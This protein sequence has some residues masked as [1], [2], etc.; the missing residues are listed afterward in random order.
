LSNFDIVIKNGLII[1]GSNSPGYV[2]D[3]GIN[4]NIITAIGQIPDE[5]SKETINAVGLA[6]TPGFI[7]I[8][9]HS[10]FSLLVNPAAESQVHQGVTSEIM[11]NCGFS[12][13]PVSNPEEMSK[14]TFGYHPSVDIT[15]RT[16]EEYLEVLSSHEPGVNTMNFV[17]HGALRQMVVGTKSQRPNPD[18]LKQMLKILEQCLDQ[19]AMGLSTGLEYWPGSDASYEELSTICEVL[20]KYD[21]FH[22]VH[23]RNRDMLFEYALAEVLSLARKTGV[24]TQIAHIQP[25]YGVPSK[26]MEHALKMIDWAREDAC[27]VSIDI[28]PNEW[29]HTIISSCLPQWAFDGGVNKLLARLKDKDTREKLKKNPNCIWQLIPDGKW[30]RLMIL[31]S[32]NN[33]Q[34][35]GKTLAEI[36]RLRDQ[37]PYDSVLDILLEE[38]ENLGRAMWAAYNFKNDDLALCLKKEYCMVMSD[39]MALAPYGKLKNTIASISGY[40][41]TARFLE[42]Y[43]IKQK[44]MPLEDGIHR[45]TGLPAVIFNIPKRGFIKPSYFADINII[46]IANI[47]D[48]STMTNLAQYPTGFDYVMV[49]GKFQMVQGKR[50]PVNNGQVLKRNIS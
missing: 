33:P 32:D 46:D 20:K 39:T 28:I 49:N 18:E 42:E 38:G 44:I 48:K 30:D 47:K 2:A 15:W 36:G 10:D 24:K 17:G 50:L 1:D 43:V 35:Q 34:Y 19:G 21:A 40:G 11:G 7:D 13:A 25:K 6:V 27:E 41:W 4:Q 14:S 16:M 12:G 23:M 45:L 8:H 37:D 31:K 5:N 3:I 26:G 29:G 22:A 9:T